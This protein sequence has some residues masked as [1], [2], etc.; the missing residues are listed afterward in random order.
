MAAVKIIEGIRQHMDLQ[1]LADYLTDA[2][3]QLLSS[4]VSLL[5]WDQKKKSFVLQSQQGLQIQEDWIPE[6]EGEIIQ[7]FS[8]NY[9]EVLVKDKIQKKRCHLSKEKLQ[10]ELQN[11]KAQICLPLKSDDNEIMGLL[12]M[13]PKKNKQAYSY[14]ELNLLKE[15][16]NQAAITIDKIKI[17]TQMVKERV[18]ANLGKIAV[19][20]AHDLNSPLNNINIFMQLLAQDHGWKQMVKADLSD[21]FFTIAQKEITRATAII[22]NLLMYARPFRTK[23]ERI[24]VNQLM[25]QVLEILG[26]RIKKSP[27]Y[28]IRQYNTEELYIPGEREQLIRVFVNLIQNAIEAM[29][30]EETK[31]LTIRTEQKKQLVKI[32]ITDTGRGIPEQIKGDLFMPFMTFGK[33]SGIGLGLSIIERF[34]ALHGG[35]IQV[36]TNYDKGAS[37][38][39]SLPLEKRGAHRKLATS[40]E[41]YRIPQ[42]EL[43]LAQDISIT[44]LRLS[45]QEYISLDKLLKLFINLADNSQPILAVGKVVW[46]KEIF[47][48]RGLPYDI[49][50]EFV[51]ISQKNRERIKKWIDSSEKIDQL[52]S[53]ENEN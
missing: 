8:S 38:V 17:Y 40:I 1:N 39:I 41:V 3:Y 16:T 45:C 26:E 24:A 25:D 7:W 9:S 2:I 35:D 14:K 53:M 32:H 49:G 42:N 51:D 21:K 22:K 43:L 30:E 31:E 23:T 20:I 46:I 37:F 11:L 50:L 27:I 6:P 18:Y 44:G 29:E 48:R 5:L 33:E 28:I 34:I 47:G 15:V 12:N 13:G 36:K 10:Q 19:Q 4:P 52:I